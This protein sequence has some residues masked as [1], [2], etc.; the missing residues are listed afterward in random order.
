MEEGGLLHYP[1]LKLC[2]VLGAWK[3]YNWKW[4]VNNRY[5]EKIEEKKKIERKKIL[6]GGGFHVVN[7]FSKG[8]GV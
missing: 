5:K 2:N 7:K 8:S 1:L 4:Y 3:Y 6:S